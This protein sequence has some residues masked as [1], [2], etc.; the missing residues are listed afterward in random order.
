MKNNVKKEDMLLYI[1]T[2]RSWLGESTLEEE[3]C[4]AIEGGATF[5]QI[6][7][8][9]MARQDFVGEARSLKG[10]AE[11]AGIPYVINDDVDIALE[12]DADGVHIG[13]SDGAV[14]EARRKIGPNKIL[15][16]SAQTLEQAL[17]AEKDGADYLGV[18]AVFSTSTKT[19]A[20]EVSFETLKSICSSVKIPVVA[21]GGINE[22]NLLELSGSKV[23]GVA[24][25]SAV[26]AQPD[27]R[28]AAQKIRKLSE[29]MVKSND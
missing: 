1:V 21:I 7:E 17:A 16:V 23:D 22:E 18:G 14:A 11:A 20:K 2:D 6:R 10:L 24:V 5:L 13:Q 8:K 27:T 12:V 4:A 3:V 26:F 25:I 15:G 28:A 9:D 19:D 29:K